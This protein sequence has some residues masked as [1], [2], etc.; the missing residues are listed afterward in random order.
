M[1]KCSAREQAFYHSN[2]ALMY[3]QSLQ[4]H[5]QALKRALEKI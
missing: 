3:L 5:L 2:P 4:Q 1:A